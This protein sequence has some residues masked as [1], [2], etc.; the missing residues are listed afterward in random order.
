M[1]IKYLPGDIIDYISISFLDSIQS[2][3]NFKLSSKD[4]N[5]IINIPFNFT[6][7]FISWCEN[8][9]FNYQYVNMDYLNLCDELICKNN[10]SIELWY[11]YIPECK[12]SLEISPTRIKFGLMLPFSNMYLNT[13]KIYMEDNPENWLWYHSIVKLRSKNS[14]RWKEL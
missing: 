13:F 14:I 10:E 8:I 5:R 11:S 1:N 7:K 12:Y 6:N 3:K 9:N 4:N 2:K